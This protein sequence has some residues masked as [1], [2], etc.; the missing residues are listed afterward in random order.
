MVW[1]ERKEQE[2]LSGSWFAGLAGGLLFC[3]NSQCFA[4]AGWPTRCS[5]ISLKKTQGVP[6]SDLGFK[7]FILVRV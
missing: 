1:L 5:R 2:E 6:S 3:T 7:M 4:N